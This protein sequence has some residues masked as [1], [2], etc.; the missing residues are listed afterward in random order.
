MVEGTS[1]QGG[2][3]E[4]GGTPVPL[5]ADR[6]PG[7]I[8]T[9][10]PSELA[11]LPLAPEDCAILAV[12][13]ETIAG[14][15]CKVLRLGPNAPSLLQLRAR[16]AERIAM[17]PLLTRRLGTDVD[18]D[19]AWVLDPDFDVAEHVVSHPHDRPVSAD[20]LRRC[21]ARLFEQR[22]DRRRP[23]WRMDLIDLEDDCRALVWRIHHAL[24]DGTA[25]LRYARTLL[26]DEA[27]ERK[28]T[29]RQAAAQHA[30]DEERRRGHLAG[31]VHRELR[32]SHDRSPFDG[33]VGTQRA[34]GFASVPLAPVHDAA[35]A[36]C[37][38]TLNDAVLSIVAGSLRRWLA[39]HHDELDSIRVK[40]PVSLHHEGDGQA[41]HDSMFV[42]GLP[43]SE[44][45]PVARLRV[46]H[47]RTHARKEA[48]DAERR[49]L[50]LHQVG[51]VSPRLEQ[52]AEQLERSPR[53][54]A[55]NVSNVFG[56]RESVS[57]L[58][59]PVRQ[60]HSLAEISRH[61]ALRVSVI[62]LADLLCFG[63]CADA[64]L[65]PDV[66]MIADQV[67]PETRALVESVSSG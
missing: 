52:L 37:G 33:Q 3:D 4:H 67:A 53:R 2:A 18:G 21:V 19:P 31:Y 45:D 29:H 64:E 11:P 66:Q 20:G 1:V 55:L 13:S 44:A 57:V 15:T 35:K 65:I 24:A 32:R 42:L 38:A 6:T 61:H 26:W 5:D 40:V 36:L 22:L 41:N 30:A 43:L 17:A 63:F 27:P 46:I 14:H 16:I 23:L 60:L 28:L 12:E 62:S 25:G 50:L 51:H 7:Q 59:A 47:D 54:F 10:A 34:I 58:A 9:D 48:R 49:E 39:A 56:P 8:G